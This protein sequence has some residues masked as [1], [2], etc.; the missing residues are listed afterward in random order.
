MPSSH[1]PVEEQVHALLDLAM[2]AVVQAR[3]LI[4]K[5]R[6]MGSDALMSDAAEALRREWMDHASPASIEE[7][8]LPRV[9]RSGRKGAKL[10]LRLMDEPD[11]YISHGALSEAVEL[12]SPS[13]DA[14]KV[15]ICHIRNALRAEG[16]SPD[17]IETGL[18]SYRVRSR[19]IKRLFEFLFQL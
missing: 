8:L 6:E 15:Y 3:M 16:Y 14:I 13:G 11:R 12:R 9:G 1:Q 4:S 10:L 19:N 18:R 2:D 17:L 7:T 5:R